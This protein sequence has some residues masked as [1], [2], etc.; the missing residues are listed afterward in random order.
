[1]ADPGI[2]FQAALIQRLQNALFGLGSPAIAVYDRVPQET[3]YPYVT[4]S[5]QQA[6][7]ADALCEEKTERFYYLSVW[8]T[9]AGQKEVLTIL[10]EIRALLHNVRLSPSQGRW[11][12]SRVTRSECVAEPDGETY[13]GRL[14][15]RVLAEH[16]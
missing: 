2:A 4:L 14:T 12:W 9:Y 8:S 15:L 6:V 10:G 3:A 7:A 13:Q 11:V 5:A 16:T 1:M